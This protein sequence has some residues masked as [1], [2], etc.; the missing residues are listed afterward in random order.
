MYIAG[1]NCLTYLFVNNAMNHPKNIL[2]VVFRISVFKK[3]PLSHNVGEI[4]WLSWPAISLHTF[5]LLLK[6][7]NAEITYV[8]CMQ[9]CMTSSQSRPAIKKIYKVTIFA[10]H[11]MLPGIR[12]GSGW[13]ICGPLVP[14]GGAGYSFFGLYLTIFVTRCGLTKNQPA[15]RLDPISTALV[16]SKKVTIVKVLHGSRVFTVCTNM[17]KKC[18]KKCE[19]RWLYL[20]WFFWNKILQFLWGLSIWKNFKKRWGKRC[21]YLKLH[22]SVDFRTLCVY[23]V[24][25]NF[26]TPKQHQS[27]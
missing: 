26:T 20:K 4:L 23:V 5:C 15:G 14:R 12:D 25:E 16:Y 8:F 11:A 9:L 27:R 6:K 1:K 19:C 13:F 3:K 17:G 21:D 2:S 22:F 7:D 24:W 10:R 18:S